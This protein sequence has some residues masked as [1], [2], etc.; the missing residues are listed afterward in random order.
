M[1]QLKRIWVTGARGLIGSHIV[2]GA[3]AK[4][5]DVV[6]PLTHSDVDLTDFKT[7]ERLFRAEE[8]DLVIH[9][10]AV[11][12]SPDCQKDPKHAWLV[13]F[14]ATK[15]L[16]ELLTDRR[17]IFFSSD[18]VFD[19]KK[20]FYVESDEPN[21][22]NVYAETKVA[23]EKA[24]LANPKHIVIRTSLNAGR[25]PRG[26]SSFTEEM[27]NAWRAGKS[28]K[29]FIDEFRCPIHARVTA[30][31]IWDLVQEYE[32]GVYHLAGSE[33]LSRYAIG[34]KLAAL[35]AAANPRIEASSLRDYSGAPRSPD[36]SLDCTKLQRLLSFPLPKFSEWLRTHPDEF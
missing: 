15:F 8:P 32:P 35:F 31:A 18:L 23:A 9:C 28:L 3:P 21:P 26:T 11:S 19:G 1:E 30:A 24:V 10:A 2:Q 17:M 33:R 12:R 29:L 6:R 5:V 13:N 7:V 36:T 25:S 14:E 16:S 20:G 34:E 22:L 27:K 4:Y